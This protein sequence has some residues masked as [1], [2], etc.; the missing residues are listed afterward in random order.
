MRLS[1]NLALGIGALLLLAACDVAAAE[2]TAN[3]DASTDGATAVARSRGASK[4][5]PTEKAPTA[6]QALDE[7]SDWTA[8]FSF[9]EEYRLRIA[10]HAL[11]TT[12]PLGEPLRTNQQTD[13]HLR[14]LGDGQISG[15][16]DHFRAIASGALWWDLD[17]GSAPGAASLFATQYDNANPWIAA[18]TLSAEWRNQ[19]ALDHARVGRQPSEHGMPITFDGGS[20]G[21]R[22][23]DRRLLI[24]AFGGRTVH[25]FETKPGLFENWVGSTGAVFRPTLGTAIE[26][27]AR[28]IS[29]QTL[30]AERARR[31]RITNGSYGLSALLRSD[32]LYA[33]A[34]ARG[35]DSRASHLGGAFQYVDEGLG[36]GFDA[37]VHAQLV[38][39]SEVVESENPFYSL[40][41]PSLPNLRFRVE[42]WKDFSIGRRENLGLH[43][44]WRGRQVLGEPEQQF[45]RNT[46]GIYFN[47]RIDDLI[48]R[49]LFVA[50]TA[51]ANYVP[52]AITREWLLAFG[53]SAGYSGTSVKT[54]VGT[55]FQQFKINYYQQAEELHNSRTVYG[56]IAYRVATWLELRARYEMDIFDR[57]LQSFFFAARQDF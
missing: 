26:F 38:T 4:A 24:F 3:L 14:L 48:E 21:V 46:G 2:T 49:G 23:L 28:A 6:E 20:F 18:Y 32:S 51:E 57:Y 10:S 56:S 37:R 15:V 41:G 31:S 53:G 7:A 8:D 40:L 36:L 22:V 9:L 1:T 54:E 44:G 35:I 13:Q 55:Y 25:F 42:S 29:E 52:R 12:G 43:L 33:K 11:P 5:Q 30:D 16:N 39:L 50:G 34:F 17:G 45:N 27:D 47:A 19:G